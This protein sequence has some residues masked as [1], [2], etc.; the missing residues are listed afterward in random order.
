M[1]KTVAQQAIR[2]L[3]QRAARGEMTAA[4]AAARVAA[5][6]DKRQLALYRAALEVAARHGERR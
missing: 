4:D 2:N 6:H 1:A 3:N 5:I